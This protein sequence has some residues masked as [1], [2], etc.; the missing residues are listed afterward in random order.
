[1]ITKSSSIFRYSFTNF[2]TSL[3][4]HS[5]GANLKWAVW[6]FTISLSSKCA[7]KTTLLKFGDALFFPFPWNEDNLLLTLVWA[8]TCVAVAVERPMPNCCGEGI[9]TSLQRPDTLEL[10]PITWSVSLSCQNVASNAPVMSQG[11][12]AIL[13]KSSSRYKVSGTIWK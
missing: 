12:L 4:L 1:M 6:V 13:V 11:N 9:R 7:K 10:S 5:S 8:L 2:A 3:T